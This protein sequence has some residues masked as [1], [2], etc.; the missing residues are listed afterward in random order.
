MAN[1]V[2]QIQPN[3]YYRQNQPVQQAQP[4]QQAPAGQ[5]AIQPTGYDYGAGVSAQPKK[6][7]LFKR[8]W[9][10]MIIVAVVAV[11]GSWYYFT[12]LAT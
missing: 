3:Q 2:Q 12:Q 4:M 8:C 9:F 5:Q 11:A 7:S 1:G 10:W 6:K